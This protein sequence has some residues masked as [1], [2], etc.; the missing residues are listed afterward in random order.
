MAIVKVGGRDVLFFLGGEG[1][2]VGAA[3]IGG[4]GHS[5]KSMPLIGREPAKF[6]RG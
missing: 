6:D 4:F 2:A 5:P 1:T 3:D